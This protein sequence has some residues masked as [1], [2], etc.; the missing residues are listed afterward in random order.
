MAESEVYRY[1]DQ[2]DKIAKLAMVRAQPSIGWWQRAESQLLKEY[3]SEFAPNRLAARWI[4]VA[5]MAD[6]LKNY[7]SWPIRFSRSSR[8]PVEF[9]MQNP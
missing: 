4:L 9:P 3:S 5:A 7:P 2:D 6:I 8:I 1:P